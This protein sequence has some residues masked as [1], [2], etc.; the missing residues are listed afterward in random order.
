MYKLEWYNS[1]ADNVNCDFDGIKMKYECTSG[2]NFIELDYANTF[3][4]YDEQLDATLE[5]N[6]ITTSTTTNAKA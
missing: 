6:S 1:L 5:R 2:V 4:N 3:V